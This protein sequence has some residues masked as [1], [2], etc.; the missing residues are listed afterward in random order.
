MS[1][2]KPF[3]NLTYLKRHDKKAY[4]AAENSPEFKKFSRRVQLAVDRHKARKHR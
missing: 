2:K 3:Q 1:H 4:H